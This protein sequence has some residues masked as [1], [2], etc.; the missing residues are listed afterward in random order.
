MC[1][2]TDMENLVV[3]AC[4]NSD[5]FPVKSLSVESVIFFVDLNPLFGC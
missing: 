3:A 4:G 5:L 1:L 2:L